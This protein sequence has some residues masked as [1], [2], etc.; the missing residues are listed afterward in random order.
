MCVAC[1]PFCGHCRTP[2]YKGV[3][4]SDCGESSVLTR[5]ECI[6]YLGYFRADQVKAELTHGDER[7]HCEKCGADIFENLVERVVPLDCLFAGIVCGFP[8]GRYRK[9]RRLGDPTCQKQT[10]LGKIGTKVEP[11]AC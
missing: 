1:N 7:P 2:L 5:E 8:C 6:V 4:C 10:P 11:V 3:D 9:E